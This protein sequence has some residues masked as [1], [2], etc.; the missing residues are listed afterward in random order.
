MYIRENGAKVKLPNVTSNITVKY[1]L[2]IL[3]FSKL[4]LGQ[5]ESHIEKFRDLEP[6]LWLGIWDMANSSEKIDIDTI[7]YDE[8]PKSIDFR[9][10]V[11]E[12][13][14]WSDTLGVNILV[15]TVTGHFNW[16]DYDDDSS[17]YMIQDKAEIYAYLY[18]K[19]DGKNSYRRLWK[20][21]DYTECFGVDWFIGFVPKA[22][23]ITDIDNDGISEVSIPYVSIC[24]GGMDPG[25][26]KII[27]Y[28]NQS[29]FAL[30]GSTMLMCD[31][32]DPYGG[33]FTASKNLTTEKY[34][35]DFLTKHWHSNKCEDGKYY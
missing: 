8:I 33:E 34:F 9:G 20:I 23:T 29:K 19:K 11:V 13:L 16:K 17:D 32:K 14:K 4:A 10:T 31:S 15:Q 25:S 21:Y 7:S 1:I 6:D 5:S 26:M 2:I 28:E 18:Q 35:L 3:A 22:T 27:M 12:A 24:R 30:R